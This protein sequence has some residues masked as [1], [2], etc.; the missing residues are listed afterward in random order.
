MKIYVRRSLLNGFLLGTTLSVAVVAVAWAGFTGPNRM[1][2]KEVRDPS[3]DEWY[4]DKSGYSRCWFAPGNPCPDKGGSHRSGASQIRVCGWPSPGNSC[5]CSK[6]YKTKTVTLPAATVGGSGYCASPG[7]DGWCLDGA[8]LELN[9]SEPVSGYVI[10]SIGHYS[11]TRG[12]L[13]P[14]RLYQ[15]QRAI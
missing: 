2:E 6:S 8:S 1:T 15:Y 13:S 3:G 4:C 5:G 14:C 7:D 12:S 10:E 11:Q 9:A